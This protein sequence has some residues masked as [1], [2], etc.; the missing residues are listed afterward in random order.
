VDPGPGAVKRPP[1]EPLPRA[2]TLADVC[3]VLALLGWISLGLRPLG[4]G[5]V[6]ALAFAANL[7]SQLDAGWRAVAFGVQVLATGGAAWIAFLVSNLAESGRHASW[8]GLAK[9]ALWVFVAICACGATAGWW[10]WAA[11]REGGH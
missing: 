7:K 9:L 5:L 2:V 6:A 10:R 3:S 1:L 8:E 11:A 4:P